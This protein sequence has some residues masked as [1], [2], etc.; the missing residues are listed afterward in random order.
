MKFEDLDIKSVYD[1]QRIS[2]HDEF[3]N[4]I[5]PHCGLY[6]RF[7]GIFSARR[8][9]LTAE[10]LQDFIKE[11]NGIMELAIIPIISESD[12]KALLQGISID[13]IIT[14]NW[15]RDLSE[16]KEKFIQD[17]TMALSWMIA[18]QFLTVKLVLPQ[19]RDGS[20]MTA[21]E[22]S[23]HPILHREIGIFYNMEDQKPVSFHGIIDRENT[24]LGEFYSI[25][26]SRSWIGD[27]MDRIEKDHE[28][29]SN[30]W[31]N[32]ICEFGNIQFQIKPLTVEL[33][34]YFEQIAPKTKEKIPLLRK[35]PGLR[36]YQKK[37]VSKWVEN[38]CRG[39]FE[40]ATGTGK[41]FT[42]IGCIKA[43][44][45][46]EECLLVVIAVPY[47]NLIG[48]WK[49]ELDKWLLP[50]TALD[51]GE[52][53]QI[54]RDEIHFLN[55]ANKKCISILITSHDLLKDEK[56]AYQ[57][58]L[59]RIPTM[60]IAD[61]AHHLGTHSSQCGLSQNYSYRLALSA[62]IDRYFDGDGTLYL[63]NYFG[64]NNRSTV[65]EFSLKK[66]IDEGMLCRY[67]Y[68]PTFIGLN[69]DE[70]TG[71]R[72]LTRKAAMLLNSKNPKDRIHGE[73]ILQ[74]RARIVRDAENK[75]SCFKEILGAMNCLSRLLIFC[76]EKQFDWI[77]DILD[78]LPKYCGIEKSVLFRRITYNNPPKVKDR[79]KILREF[80]DEEWDVLL[81]N[82]VLDE[83][84]D[85]PQAQN[86]VVL[87]STGNPTQ[88]VQ[89]RGRVMRIYDDVYKDGAKKKFARIY[90]VLVKPQIDNLR[91][92]DAIKLEISMIRSQLRRLES[93]GELAINNDECAK[94]ISEFTYGLPSEVFDINK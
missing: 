21:D 60:L 32:E 35:P 30:F 28:E 73:Y 14:R 81:S 88:F 74:K 55:T 6:R 49:E 61:E 29:F 56:F 57:I 85:I 43:I 37:A 16:I 67:Y 39:I 36:P 94:K 46:Q 26:V 2:V 9:S 79:I 83:G 4:K 47:S 19:H 76:S 25:D 17:H 41:T 87:A 33:E 34:S 38:G 93:M 48:Q 13:N 11:N 68:Y 66:A 84:M 77:E 22:L 40:M 62:T 3:F 31:D 18:N 52:W 45:S 91:D 89:R 82:R 27:E 24:E 10:G 59:A 1:S 92:P 78:D 72:N 64:Q 50:S 7:G 12:K 80:A 44:Q 8:F 53:G 71:Y 65:F 58:K 90:D 51:S 75:H 63:R 15:I 20:F 69:K 54:L 70:L 42:G 23:R 86:C 5:L